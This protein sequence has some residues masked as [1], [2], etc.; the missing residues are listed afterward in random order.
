MSDVHPS[1][2]YSKLNMSYANTSTFVWDDIH[3]VNISGTSRTAKVVDFECS[4]KAPCTG[5]SFEDIDLAAANN[6]NSSDSYICQNL[7]ATGLG[8][9]H[10]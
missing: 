4:S 7:N 2:T 3:F 10:G 1:L 5:W 6:T 8:Q 9:C